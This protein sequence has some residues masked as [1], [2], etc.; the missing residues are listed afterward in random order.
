MLEKFLKFI[1]GGNAESSVNASFNGA[2]TNSAM[3]EHVAELG[4]KTLTVAESQPLWW[5]KSLDESYPVIPEFESRG[6]V[7]KPSAELRQ[8]LS[9]RVARVSVKMPSSF[10]L[11]R[12]LNNPDVT[13]RRIT[14]IAGRDPVFAA[15]LLRT[16]NSAWFG[17][18]EQVSSLGRAIVLLGYNNVKALALQQSFS[19]KASQSVHHKELW[20]H[21]AVTA[22]VAAVLARKIPGQDPAQ[23][24]TVALLHDL[25]GILMDGA[26]LESF[27]QK[28]QV[29]AK[30]VESL[31]GGLLATHWQLP[32]PI[33]KAVEEYTWPLYFAT[34]QVQA[35][36]DMQS[37]L[38]CLADYYAN[39]FGFKDITSK[40]A[41]PTV[42]L[43]E[44]GLPESPREWLSTEQLT[45]I[46][47][48]RMVMESIF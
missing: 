32:D 21:S 2:S 40:Y 15:A 31:L 45:E 22:A 48:T 12:A 13:T 42:F 29:P 36:T 18:R 16:V 5:Q 9:E 38:V 30:V 10:E 26:D 19:G 6:D 11:F 37:R 25:G 1:S 7:E 14:D 33:C 28:I 34:D 4:A 46:D 8:K 47:K 20:V 17:L 35:Q 23:V 3:P 41:P 43:E 44:F 27:A 39:F 24:A